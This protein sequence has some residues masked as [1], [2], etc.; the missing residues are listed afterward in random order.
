MKSNSCW[1]RELR[2]PTAVPRK[3]SARQRVP[4]EF[5]NEANSPNKDV[6]KRVALNAVLRPIRSEPDDEKPVR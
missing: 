4:K 3:N 6:K 2:T 1:S 5:A